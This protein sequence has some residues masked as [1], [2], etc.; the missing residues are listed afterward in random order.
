[1]AMKMFNAAMLAT[2]AGV[3]QR[4]VKR[5]MRPAAFAKATDAE[6]QPYAAVMHLTLDELKR[7]PGKYLLNIVKAR[8]AKASLP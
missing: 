4:T 7:I 5:H 8:I 6:L 2:Y 3:R 1:M